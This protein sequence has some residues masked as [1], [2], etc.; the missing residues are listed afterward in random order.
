[1]ALT[2]APF[3]GESVSSF[4]DVGICEG[5]AMLVPEMPRANPKNNATQA[6]NLM[7]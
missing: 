1:M 5:A 6:A 4:E 7:L 2:K 3:I